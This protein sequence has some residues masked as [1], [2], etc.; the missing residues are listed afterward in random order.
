[1]VPNGLWF[2]HPRHREQQ[3]VIITPGR[4]PDIVTD[5][6]WRLAHRRADCGAALRVVPSGEQPDG[7]SETYRLNGPLVR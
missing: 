4:G 6:R 5:E 1:M 2:L 7:N 3:G